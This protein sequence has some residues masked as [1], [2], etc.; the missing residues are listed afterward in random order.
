MQI[1]TIVSTC[2]AKKCQLQ[3]FIYVCLY[4]I[5]SQ[6]NIFFENHIANKLLE[7]PLRTVNFINFRIMHIK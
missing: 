6:L 4:N 7:L 2:S 1:E 3:R 5:N